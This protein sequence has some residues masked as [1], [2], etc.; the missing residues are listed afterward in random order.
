MLF[1]VFMIVIVFE[2]GSMVFVSLLEVMI[3]FSLLVWNCML[4]FLIVI[5]KCLSIVV[6]G[7]I[8]L[9]FVGVY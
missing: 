7:V 3:C 6:F 9:K 1:S 5:L 4:C 2:G 8:N